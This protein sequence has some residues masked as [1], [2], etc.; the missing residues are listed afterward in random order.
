M[1]S[2]LQVKQKGAAQASQQRAP[3]GDNRSSGERQAGV[4]SQG[5]LLWVQGE[6]LGTRPQGSPA[7]MESSLC[8]CPRMALRESGAA[9]VASPPSSLSPDRWLY[10]DQA[11]IFYKLLWQHKPK[12]W[13]HLVLAG[14]LPG[15]GTH[16]ALHV[17]PQGPVARW[18]DG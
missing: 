13:A 17:C 1:S 3:E 8:W 15:M 9:L 14:I 5:G 7:T 2:E 11:V 18:G 12:P 10:K 6:G 16:R 4:G